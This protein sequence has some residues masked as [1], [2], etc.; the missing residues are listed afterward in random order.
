MDIVEYPPTKGL[1]GFVKVFVCAKNK[2]VCVY[3]IYL[4]MILN[5]N[6]YITY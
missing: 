2:R 6:F 4:H 5:F 1:K 3:N